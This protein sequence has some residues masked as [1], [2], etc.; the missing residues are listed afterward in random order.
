MVSYSTYLIEVMTVYAITFVIASSS[1][2][3]PFRTYIMRLFPKLKIKQHKHFIECRMC[4]SF[5]ISVLVCLVY[6]DIS[7]ILV[8]YGTSYFL[9]T[10]ER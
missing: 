9:A 2:F 8:V 5:W 1:L 10:Q 6:S 7:H 4:I 3:D